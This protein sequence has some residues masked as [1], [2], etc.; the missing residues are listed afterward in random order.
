M[1]WSC[2]GQTK[3]CNKIARMYENEERIH[4]GTLLCLAVNKGYLKCLEK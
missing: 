1:S 4:G 3:K 2:D